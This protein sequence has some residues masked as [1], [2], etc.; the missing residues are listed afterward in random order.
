MMKQMSTAHT[1]VLRHGMVWIKEYG[2]MSHRAFEG[3]QEE[4]LKNTE[5]WAYILCHKHVQ[6]MYLNKSGK[7]LIL[8]GSK[9]AMQI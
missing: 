2:M 6:F 7:N 8:L 3:V 1:A 9:L 5:F 4:E